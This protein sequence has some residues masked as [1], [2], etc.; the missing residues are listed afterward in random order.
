M[1]VHGGALKALPPHKETSAR[2]AVAVGVATLLS[3][4][5]KGTLGAGR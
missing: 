1:L 3:F 2:L 5:A 4:N